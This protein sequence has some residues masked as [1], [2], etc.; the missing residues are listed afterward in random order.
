[1]SAASLTVRVPEITADDLVDAGFSS[2]EIQMLSAMRDN[3]PFIEYV[4]TSGQWR[5]L[6]FLKWRYD[7]GDLQRS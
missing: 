2:S 3:Y 7:Y 6:M 4:E 1:M 5:R